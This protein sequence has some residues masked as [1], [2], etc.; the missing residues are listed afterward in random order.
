MNKTIFITGASS[1]IGKA[2]ALLKQ[3]QNPNNT[4]SPP[5]LVA[6][7]IYNAVTDG[8]TQLRYRAGDDANFL[9]DNRKKMTDEE[10]FS[11]MNNQ[12]GK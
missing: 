11:M 6:E 7:V 3:W 12:M 9:L 1:G 2:T 4:V 5:S 10:F 8:S